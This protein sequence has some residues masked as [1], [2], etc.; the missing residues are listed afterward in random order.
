MFIETAGTLFKILFRVKE[1]PR[2][3]LTVN[4]YARTWLFPVSVVYLKPNRALVFGIYLIDLHLD[5]CILVKSDC[6]TSYS[7]N[8][9]VIRSVVAIQKAPLEV[10]YPRL[11]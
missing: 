6:K 4:S 2:H 9:L 11:S 10:L 3:Q 8:G 7:Q 5:R 1:A